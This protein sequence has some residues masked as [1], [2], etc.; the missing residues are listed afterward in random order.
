MSNPIADLLADAIAIAVQR[1]E[2]I[3]ALRAVTAPAPAAEARGLVAKADAARALG[4]SVSTLDR[5]ARDGAPVHT[6]GGRRRYEVRELRAWL[7]DRG[8]RSTRATPTNDRVDVD[9]VL[10]RAGLRLAGGG[11]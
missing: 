6:V 1:P 2:I 3:A 9:D 11:K 4:V 10:A 7:D 8:Q 5:L